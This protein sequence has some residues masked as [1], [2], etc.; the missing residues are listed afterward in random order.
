[1]LFTER[2]SEEFL[3]LNCCGRQFHKQDRGSHRP[4]GR[5]DY[6]ILYISKGCCYLEEQGRELM[7]EAGSLI[8]YRP[9]EPQHYW[10][11]GVENSVSD[12]IHFSG[13]GCG[14]L[15]DR[16]GFKERINRVGESDLLRN[17]FERLL[18]ARFSTEPFTADLCAALL[19][20]YLVAAGRAAGQGSSDRIRDICRRMQEELSAGHSIGYYAELCG[21][22]ESRFSH[23][24]KERVGSSPK[25]YLSEQQVRRACS[26]LSATDLPVSAVA[27]AVGIR[28]VNYFC[29]LIRKKTG[30]SPLHIRFE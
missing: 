3:A 1:M 17:R 4:K 20:E 26:L 23:L 7:A 15:L 14:A 28:D 25:Q 10:F 5:R 13:T 16:L 21:L 8:L 29:R 27:A 19:Y 11:R 22:S 9:G 24:F 2:V 12:Y 18:E 6:H 30:N